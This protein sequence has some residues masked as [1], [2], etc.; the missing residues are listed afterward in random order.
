MP[1]HRR[2]FTQEGKGYQPPNPT[3]ANAYSEAAAHPPFEFDHE[4]QRVLIEVAQDVCTR[5][6]WRL[7]AGATEVTHIHAL[8]SWRDDA[9][10]ED[11]RGK[12]RNIMS[13]EL[14]RRNDTY[15]RP[16]FVEGASRKHV[17]REAHF[18]YLMETYLPDHSGW[19]WSERRGWTEP[20]S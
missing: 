17:E 19:R 2:G 3:L 20:R 15:G 14:S 7:H 13:L 12:L 10:W 4:T 18:E 8:T 5:R 16:W 11:V 9:R 6:D 1:D